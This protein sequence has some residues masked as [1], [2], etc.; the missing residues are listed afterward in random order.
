MGFRVGIVVVVEYKVILL[1][2]LFYRYYDRIIRPI[3]RSRHC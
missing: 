1:Y 2:E 3:I